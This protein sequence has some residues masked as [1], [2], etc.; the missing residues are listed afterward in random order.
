MLVGLS[1]N[2]TVN[3]PGVPLKFAAGTKRNSPV[4]ATNRA[5]PALTDGKASHV[6]MLEAR[7]CHS[8]WPLVAVLSTIAT[9]ASVFALEPPLTESVASLKLLENSVLTVAPGAEVP[10]SSATAANVALPEATGA[11]FTAL[12]VRL[13][14][15]ANVE[16][17]VVP[18]VLVVLAVPPLLPAIVSH[19]R[20]VR[21]LVRTPFKLESG[22]RYNRLFESA[23]SR[24]AV[25]GAAVN[26]LHVVPLSVE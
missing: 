23:E 3:P 15:S 20:T 6:A 14:V 7:Y 21:A 2:R 1:T 13:T 24:S 19:A 17:E 5:P 8:P 9:P 11:S 25:A 16:N 10:T 26:E 4:A 22:C 12:I 18:P